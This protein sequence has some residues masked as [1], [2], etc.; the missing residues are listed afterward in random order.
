MEVQLHHRCM[1]ILH[2][3]TYKST[4]P[5]RINSTSCPAVGCEAVL[6][7]HCSALLHDQP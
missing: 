1:H 5:F 3:N 6:T 4:S 7:E 2:E